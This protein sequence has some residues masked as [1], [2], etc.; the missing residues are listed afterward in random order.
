MGGQPFP[1]KAA[2]QYRAQPTRS[3]LTLFTGSMLDSRKTVK[4]QPVKAP[5]ANPDNQVQSSEL[6]EFPKLSSDPH[7]RSNTITKFE[8]L[9]MD[10]I[11]SVS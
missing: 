1:A 8:Q 11:F 4:G 2:K 3:R 6:K 5:A 7:L 9:S 10:S